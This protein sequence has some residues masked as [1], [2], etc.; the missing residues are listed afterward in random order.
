[1]DPEKPYRAVNYMVQGSAADLLKD[2]MVALEELLVKLR[3]RG[4]WIWQVLTIHDEIVVEVRTDDVRPW[5]LRQIRTLMEDHTGHFG[6]PTPV[7]I[8]ITKLDWSRKTG[9]EL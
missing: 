9:L 3:E 2:R 6:I 1:V 5:L 8:A 4:I 7:E